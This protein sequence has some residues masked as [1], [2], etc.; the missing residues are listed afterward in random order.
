MGHWGECKE[1]YFIFSNIFEVF[2]FFFIIK[3][4]VSS[5]SFLSL[6]WSSK[7]PQQNIDQ[8]E[9]GI[10]DKKLSVEL[11]IEEDGFIIFGSR[12]E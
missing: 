11:C 1:Y 5:F 4:I 12:K 7:F 2:F 6:R 10:G 3:L 8:S 9:I